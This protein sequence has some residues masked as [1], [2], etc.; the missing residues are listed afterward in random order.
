MEPADGSTSDGDE[1]HRED[2][3]VTVHIFR[4]EAVPHLWKVGPSDEK[5]HHDAESHEQ[6]HEGEKRIHLPDDFVDREHRCQKIIKEDDDNPE[7][8]VEEV[9]GNLVKDGG[10][11]RDEGDADKH[12]EYYGE[13]HHY[14]LN[15]ISEVGANDLGEAL[16]A[17]SDRN[18][19]GDEVMHRAGEDGA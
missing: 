1:H 15:D 2:R 4:A 7:V 16:A 19:G 17:T 9:G 5:H 14:L 11:L 6:Q 18:H 12:H 3:R 13:H 8:E 10:R